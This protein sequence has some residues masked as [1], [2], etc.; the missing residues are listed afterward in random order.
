MGVWEQ[1][2]S[3]STGDVAGSL[4]QE[5]PLEEEMATHS[6]ILAWRISWTEEPGGLQFIESQRIGYAWA[7]KH[8]KYPPLDPEQTIWMNCG[9]ALSQPQKDWS[10]EVSPD[11]PKQPPATANPTPKK[12]RKEKQLGG[13]FQRP[14]RFKPFCLCILSLQE[15]GHTGLWDW[16]A[17]PPSHFTSCLSLF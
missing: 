4:G 11:S 8:A 17:W 15:T 10:E 9:K 5:D 7:T 12:K 2:L 14:E 6:S 1:L 16:A 13:A 3:S